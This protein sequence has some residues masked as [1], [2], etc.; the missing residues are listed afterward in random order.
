MRQA[1]LESRLPVAIVCDRLVRAAVQD[2]AD[3]IDSFPLA[4]ATTQHEDS[5]DELIMGIACI[6]ITLR[7]SIFAQHKPR[8]TYGLAAVAAQHSPEMFS[9]RR[10][11]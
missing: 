9:C 5:G 4:R 3:R 10:D 2:L 8:N 1:K 6:V 7:L 11:C